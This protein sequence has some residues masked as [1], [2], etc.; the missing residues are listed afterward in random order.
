[1]Q[2]VVTRAEEKEAALQER[3]E[4]AQEVVVLADR[5]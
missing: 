3:Y 5:H 4:E 2:A 1:M